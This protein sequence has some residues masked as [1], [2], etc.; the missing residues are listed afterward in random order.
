MPGLQ[1]AAFKPCFL[2][3]LQLLKVKVTNAAS[4]LVFQSD[5]LKG[6]IK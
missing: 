4:K 3:H 2:L 1:K 5:N 6:I